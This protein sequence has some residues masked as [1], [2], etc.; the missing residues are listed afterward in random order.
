[1][2]VK[3]VK[4]T[5][6]KEKQPRDEALEKRVEALE[7]DKDENEVEDEDQQEAYQEEEITFR[8]QPNSN[9][10][11][12]QDVLIDIDNLDYEWLRQPQLVM[13]YGELATNLEDVVRR[14]ER[15]IGVKKAQEDVKIRENARRKDEKL[16]EAAIKAK[17]E[18]KSAQFPE[19]KQLDLLLYKAALV[20]RA[21]AALEHKKKSLEWISQLYQTGYFS[22]PSE[23]RMTEKS[24]KIS[25]I[26]ND[27]MRDRQRDGLNKDSEELIEAEE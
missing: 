26:V 16:T 13:D 11:Y 19:T 2:P 6:K 12:S 18:E 24:K 3:K 21:L 27:R 10:D 15:R 25:E 20:R 17:I 1:M 23:K 22:T 7:L 8:T 5:S 14:L 9:L 4:K